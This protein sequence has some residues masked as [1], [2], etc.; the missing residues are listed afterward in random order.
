MFR[1][2]SRAYP[3]GAPHTVLQSHDGG[4]QKAQPSIDLEELGRL[5]LALL[6]KGPGRL[7]K[8]TLPQGKETERGWG[9][10]GGGVGQESR[11]TCHLLRRCRGEAGVRV[12]Q[13]R[14]SHCL[15]MPDMRSKSYRK[16]RT[17]RFSQPQ[18]HLARL[19]PQVRPTH[20]SHSQLQVIRTPL[21]RLPT[22]PATLTTCR[23]PA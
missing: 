8:V 22:L 1:N 16:C 2:H 23:P 3:G 6:A 19:K 15:A 17:S 13:V 9:G 20:C 5:A 14:S 21:L 18:K 10:V 12:A 7:A 11:R 4:S